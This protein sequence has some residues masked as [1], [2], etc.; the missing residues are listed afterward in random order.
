MKYSGNMLSLTKTLELISKDFKQTNI[1]LNEYNYYSNV[2]TNKSNP[3][4]LYRGENDF[5][6]Q[7]LSNYQRLKG[8]NKIEYDILHKYMFDL[9]E[10]L[11]K[12][13][14]SIYDQNDPRYNPTIIELGAFLQH[15]GFPLHWLDLTKNIFVAAFFAIYQNTSGRGRIGIIETKNLINL[16]IPIYKLNG[17]I[18]RRPSIQEAFAIKVFDDIPDFKN[19]SHYNVKWIDLLINKDDVQKFSNSKILSTIGDQISYTVV[20]YIIANPMKS[21]KVKN[22]VN[23]IKDDLISCKSI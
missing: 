8:L 21:V 6:P 15:Y 22:I 1:L 18:A 14:F 5:Y 13:Y 17:S 19:T 20:N 7:T 9:S 12:K 3:K 2:F 11:A 16:N 10:F 23:K 4:F